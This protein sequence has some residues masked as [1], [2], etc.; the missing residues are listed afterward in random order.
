MCNLRPV[1]SDSPKFVLRYAQKFELSCPDDITKHTSAVSFM[2]CPAVYLP[3]CGCAHANGHVRFHLVTMSVWV[4]R[5]RV[6]LCVCAWV[7]TC[8]CA[9]AVSPRDH[10]CLCLC[11]RVSL[12]VRPCVTTCSCARSCAVSPRDREYTPGRCLY[13]YPDCSGRASICSYCGWESLGVCGV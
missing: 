1:A 3:M 4:V 13:E 9:R 5:A 7:S 8:L 10:E 11:V 12:C 6:L 2:F